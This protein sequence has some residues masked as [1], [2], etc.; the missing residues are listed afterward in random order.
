[1]EKLHSAF[2][3]QGH[4]TMERQSHLCQNQEK[5]RARQ[6]AVLNRASAPVSTTSRCAALSD[7]CSSSLPLPQVPPVPRI[8]Q[9]D[10]AIMGVQCTTL[11]LCNPQH[12][13]PIWPSQMLPAV[14]EGLP[15]GR[16]FKPIQARWGTWVPEELPTCLRAH[17]VGNEP[18]PGGRP[19]NPIPAF[20]H[21]FANQSESIYSAPATYQCQGATQGIPLRL[22]WAYHLCL[23]IFTDLFIHYIGRFQ[24]SN[25]EKAITLTELF[26]NCIF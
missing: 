21:P 24:K 6:V 23:L 22:Q 1:M 13:C 25:E 15:L 8:P 10:F 3:S 5:G 14:R 20:S 11:S 17:R 4:T 19:G 2:T 26:K 9:K 16:P 12:P 7:N 18:A